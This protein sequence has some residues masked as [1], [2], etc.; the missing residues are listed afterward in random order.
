MKFKL[1]IIN[2]LLIL[3]ILPNAVFLI[4]WFKWYVSLPTLAVI[5]YLISK[6]EIKFPE[7]KKQNSPLLLFLTLAVS[8]SIAVL[9]GTCNFLPQNFDFIKHNLITCDLVNYQWP[10]VYDKFHYLC[11][12]IAYYLIPAGIAKLF[13]NSAA[14][15]FL[16]GEL[17]LVVFIA[18]RYVQIYVTKNVFHSFLIVILPNSIFL[19]RLL[20]YSLVYIKEIYVFSPDVLFGN[21]LPLY[22]EIST[23]ITQVVYVPQHFCALLIGGCL[24]HYS[25]ITKNI[26]LGVFICIFVPLWSVFTS[27]AFLLLL[28]FQILIFYKDALKHRKFIFISLLVFFVFVSYF[29]GHGL[30][31]C[32]RFW[33]MNLIEIKEIIR[34]LACIAIPYV[35]FF[36]FAFFSKKT[37]IIQNIKSNVL[38]RDPKTCLLLISCMLTPFFL[39]YYNFDFMLR[40]CATFL[41]FVN[42][43][44]L[45]NLDKLKTLYFYTFIL[46]FSIGIITQITLLCLNLKV[47][48]YK[49]SFKNYHY[50]LENKKTIYDLDSY[51]KPGIK[52]H[53]LSKKKN[54]IFYNYLARKKH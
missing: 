26:K 30:T 54:S 36:L 9:S 46:I 34:F 25:W 2:S 6:L 47:D 53:Y 32:R 17:I 24:M 22:L 28:F 42:L 37:P 52:F 23:F 13:S 35:C 40:G 7:R 51:H 38:N 21:P 12:N 14:E 20:L 41:F 43:I 50:Y 27:A 49:Y 10:V 11:Y 39:F 33:Q 19:V 5:F 1:T 45:A 15:Y 48:S 4:F 44:M 16:F 3:L 31:G 29:S 18:L 8:F